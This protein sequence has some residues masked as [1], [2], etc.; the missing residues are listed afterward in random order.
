[1]LFQKL[2][3]RLG[4]AG[5]VDKASGHIHGHT[6]HG[7]PGFSFGKQKIFT[8]LPDFSF[9]SL[10]KEFL[11]LGLQMINFFT[12]LCGHMLFQNGGRNAPY[13]NSEA[14]SYIRP[15]FWHGG[16]PFRIKH[17]VNVNETPCFFFRHV[18]DGAEGE[19]LE[20][21]AGDAGEE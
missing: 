4:G 3:H 6:I 12:D 11:S 5:D 18:V 17:V 20:L 21:L 16:G 8:V 9:P 13:V 10:G 14:E 19:L 15:L 2:K 1:M 7:G